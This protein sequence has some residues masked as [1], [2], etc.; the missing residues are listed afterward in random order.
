MPLYSDLLKNTNTDAPCLDVNDLQIQGYGI[1]ADAG[2][3]DILNQTIRTEGYIAS[4]KDDDKLYIYTNSDLSDAQWVDANNW[5]LAGGATEGIDIS[6]S[7]RDAAY[8]TAGDNEGTLLTMGNL[9]LIV[10]KVYYWDAVTSEWANANASTASTSTGLLSIA[11]ASAAS[12]PTLVSG[13]IQ[14]TAA[15][16]NA[17]DVLYLD[18]T[19]G[20]LTATAPS[21]SGN[22]VR[23]C[24]Y[25]LGGNRVYFDPSKDWLEIV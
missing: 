11:T 14:M 7:I 2:V 24:G 4:M 12:A 20:L 3:R 6:V 5:V 1:F 21:G 10:E 8:S 17:G 23:V 19:N 16:G 15:P 22:I 9:G 25:N 18:T 13:I